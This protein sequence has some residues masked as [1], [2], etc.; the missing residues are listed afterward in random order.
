M[1]Y[2][3]EFYETATGKSPVWEFFEELRCN[4]TKDKNF[5]IQYQQMGMY[6]QLLQA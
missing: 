5:R 6:M 4:S 3:V 1:T 2:N